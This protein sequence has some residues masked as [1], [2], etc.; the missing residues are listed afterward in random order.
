[1]KTVETTVA[2]LYVGNVEKWAWFS[3]SNLKSKRW[4]SFLGF[5]EK[6]GSCFSASTLY[7]QPFVMI[8]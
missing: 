4:K 8:D 1:M 7:C 5:H 6:I 3:R 2:F